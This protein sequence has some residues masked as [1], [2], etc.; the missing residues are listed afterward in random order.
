ME[1]VGEPD[2][3]SCAVHGPG[4]SGEAALVNK[5]FFSNGADATGWHI[6]TVHWAP[7]TISFEVDGV[8]VYR[9][10]RPMVDFFGSWV[11]DDEKYLILNFALGGTYPFKTNGIR[12]PYY[13]I[14]EETINRIKDDE[15]RVMI[16]W[17]RVTDGGGALR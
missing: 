12:S 13:G 6:Y 17:V 8:T 1:Y 9:V 7:D 14:A 3:V 16:D 5:L 10:T 4:Y 11:F 2:W 15:T